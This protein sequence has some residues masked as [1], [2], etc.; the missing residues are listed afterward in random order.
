MKLSKY[1]C[2]I[3]VTV[4][5]TVLAAVPVNAKT[6]DIAYADGNVDQYFVEAVNEQLSYL[7]DTLLDKFVSE[8]WSINVT[9][10]NI[11]Q[12][13]CEGKWG[14]VEGIIL[15]DYNIISIENR[16]IAVI[17]STLHEIGHYIDFVNGR[18]SNTDEFASIYSEESDIY[19][20]AFEYYSHY[21]QRDMFADGVWKY[22]T[23]REKLKENC[24]MLY[25]YL[26]K[27]LSEHYP[28]DGTRE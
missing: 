27:F 16:D 25:D 15:Y 19:L 24:P 21:S 12:Y 7:P 10:K 4:L 6:V 2:F 23:D 14:S 5:S 13:Y 1:R 28:E 26:D 18:P 3:K 20:S 17:D 8:G 11:D 22:Y 9:D